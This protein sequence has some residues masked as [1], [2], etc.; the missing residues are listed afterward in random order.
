[1][2]KRRGFDRGTGFSGFAS[3][4]AENLVSSVGT[5]NSLKPTAKYMSGARAVLKVNGSIVGFA[6][7]I[8]WTINTEQV[9]INTIDDYMPYEIAPRRISVNGTIG[10][11]VI[12]GRSPTAELIQSD[13]LSFLFN[14]YIT[15]EIRDSVTD[16]MLFKTN[17]AVITSSSSDLRAEQLGSTTLQW[18]AIGW[19]NESAPGLPSGYNDA[20]DKASA[21]PSGII[22]KLKKKIPKLP[23]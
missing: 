6:M 8:S 3:R 9:E 4:T 16:N 2:S 23:F 13:S 18:K 22:D 21:D 20:S 15:I 5:I 19:V 12:P 14:K 1:M 7:Q 17:K 10:T 11:F